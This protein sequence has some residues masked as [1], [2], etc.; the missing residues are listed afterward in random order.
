[1]TPLQLEL[2]QKKQE[3]LKDSRIADLQNTVMTQGTTVYVNAEQVS[4]MT[5]NSGGFSGT[6]SVSGDINNV[7][8]ENNQQRVSKKISNFY[9][10]N[11]QFGGGLVNADTV[12]ANQIG[13]NITN[14]NPEQ[15]QNLADAAAEI[16]QLL[17]HLSQSYP[18]A[19]TSE[20]MTVVAKAVDEIENNPTL[21]ARVIGALKAGGTEA[22][23]EL[24]DNP[25]INI[26]AIPNSKI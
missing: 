9:L 14:Y 18:T 10:Q 4:F 26:P 16:Q 3:S 25:L 19:T 5:N 20:K 7:Q 2:E 6:G 11:A 1:V 12:K 24:I 23:K 17:N 8:G 22:F 21:K 15:K 13:G